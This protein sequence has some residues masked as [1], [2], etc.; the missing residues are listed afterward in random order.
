MGLEFNAVVETRQIY[1]IWDF[2]SDVGG[3]V[4]VL[5]LLGYPVISFIQLI[6]GNGLSRLLIKSIFKIQR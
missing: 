6:L 5:K 4:D 1:T 2:L 3:L